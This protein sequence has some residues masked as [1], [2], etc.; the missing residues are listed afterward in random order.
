[1]YNRYIPQPDGSHRRSPVN[2]GPPQRRQNQPQNP[3]PP[4]PDPVPPACQE[5]KYTPPAAFKAGEFLRRL[6]PKDLDTGDLLIIVLLLLMS[7][8]CQEEKNSALLTLA[9]YLFM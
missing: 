1:M 8:D 6:I 7:A 3:A 9:L 5:S 2:S 4:P